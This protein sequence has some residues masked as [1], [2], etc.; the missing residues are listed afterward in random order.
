MGQY[1]PKSVVETIPAGTYDAVVKKAEDQVSKSGNDMI[2]LI[3]TVY[4]PAGIPVD[5]FDYLVF[6]NSMLYKVKH[7]CDSAGL[8]FDKG[9][10]EAG[11]CV[12]KNV[13]VK[14]KVESDDEYGDQN[15]VADYV[16]RNGPSP[17]PTAA[18]PKKDEE[19]PF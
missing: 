10:L 11:D 3:L 7:F 13:R 8:N 15:K 17:A 2:K 5:V 18:K 19:I 12:D 14:L 4:T 9:E 1:D 6:Q 16:K